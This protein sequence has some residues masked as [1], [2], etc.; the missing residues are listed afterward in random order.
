MFAVLVDAS[1][2]WRGIRM[3]PHIEE[4]LK[5]MAVDPDWAWTDP[6]IAKF[7]A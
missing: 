1:E 5:Q 2:G 4:R 3:A 7:V 6:D